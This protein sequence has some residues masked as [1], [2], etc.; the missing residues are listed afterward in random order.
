[1]LF[2]LNNLSDLSISTPI[3]LDDQPISRPSMQWLKLTTP[4]PEGN[5]G[6]L[7]GGANKGIFNSGISN[8]GDKTSLT[9]PLEWWNSKDL[10]LGNLFFHFNSF[11]VIGFKEEFLGINQRPIFVLKLGNFLIKNIYF[12]ISKKLNLNFKAIKSIKNN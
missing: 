2:A 10:F 8:I 6:G 7:E 12:L 4:I 9:Y 5:K 1:M 3:L 11:L